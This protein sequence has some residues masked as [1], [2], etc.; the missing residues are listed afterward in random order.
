MIAMQSVLS[1]ADIHIENY[2]HAE[3]STQSIHDSAEQLAVSITENDELHNVDCHQGHC[4][5]ASV[6]YLEFNNTDMIVDLASVQLSQVALSINSPL[7][8]PDLR[9]PIA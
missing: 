3:I 8:S 5:H 4:H 2:N 1:I 6:V 7:I 9:P